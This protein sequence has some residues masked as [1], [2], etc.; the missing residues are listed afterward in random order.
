MRPFLETFGYGAIIILL[1]LGMQGGG[2]TVGQ[3]IVSMGC[4]FLFGAVA[5]FLVELGK[6]FYRLLKG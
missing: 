5:R 3:F 2:Q 4:L 1:L 6:D